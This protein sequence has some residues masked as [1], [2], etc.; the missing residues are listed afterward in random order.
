MGCSGDPGPDP[1]APIGRPFALCPTAPFCCACEAAGEPA[2][3]LVGLFVVEAGAAPVVVPAGLATPAWLF[4]GDAA[5]V[6]GPPGL[7]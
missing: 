7:K 2:G 5:L 1:G 6:A 4:V 3:A